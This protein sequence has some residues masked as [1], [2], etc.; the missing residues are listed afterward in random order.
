[1]T[2]ISM[3]PICLRCFPAALIN[4]IKKMNKYSMTAS[5]Q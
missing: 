5:Q 2:P 3:P 4:L 1:M